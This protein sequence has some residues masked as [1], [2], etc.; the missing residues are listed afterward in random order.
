[1]DALAT[2]QL[3]KRLKPADTS[4]LYHPPR[5]TPGQHMMATHLNALPQLRKELAFIQT[6]NS[7]SAIIARDADQ[8]EFRRIGEGVLRHWAACFVL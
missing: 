3:G 7:H 2:R 5:I 6:R 4:E 8:F 1:M